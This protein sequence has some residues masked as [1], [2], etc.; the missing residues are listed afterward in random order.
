MS[1]Y[2]LLAPIYDEGGFANYA[3][4]I[5]PRLILQMQQDDWLGRRILDLGCGTGVSCAAFLNSSFDVY[6]IDD[7]AAMLQVANTQTQGRG[8][9]ELIEGDIRNIAFPPETDL[10]YCIGNVLNELGS[11]KD[12]HTVLQKAYA[13]LQPEKRLIF[14]L[15]TLRGLGEYLGTSKQILDISEQ[16]FLAVQNEFNYENLSLRQQFSL[17][18]QTEANRWQRGDAQLTL[19]GYPVS[20][21][22]T[23]LEKIGFKVVYQWNTQLN[24]FDPANDTDGRVIIVAQK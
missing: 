12:I 7:N 8:F 11:L 10:V 1:V 5:T 20:T 15:L 16:T 13:S 18:R 4:F 19:R 21:V 17:F 2:N 22:L 14:D 24:T 3:G 6:G 23:L 9:C